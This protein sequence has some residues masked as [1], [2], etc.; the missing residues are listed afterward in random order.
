MD[1]YQTNL[2]RLRLVATERGLKL[3]PDASRVEKVAGLMV[4]NFDA[5]GEWICPC[6]QKTRPAA[7]GC[8]ITCP[9]PT[10]AAEIAAA[11]SCHCRLFVA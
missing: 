2:H 10:L 1:T 9:C 8:D 5:V 11:G 6:K 4:R 7:K 3:N